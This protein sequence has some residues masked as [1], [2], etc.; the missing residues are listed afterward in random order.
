[1]KQ[2][3]IFLKKSRTRQF[4]VLGNRSGQ[5]MIEYVLMLVVTISLLFLANKVFDSM[6]KFMNKYMGDYISCLMEYGELPSWGVQDTDLKQHTSGAGGGKVCDSSFD[7]FTI[8]GG[9]PASGG[10]GG[11]GGG[12]N[13]S[14]GKNEAPGGGKNTGSKNNSNASN[15][16]SSQQS[17]SSGSSSSSSSS[18]SPYSSGQVRR[19]GSSAGGRAGGTTD[20]RV[21]AGE[22]DEKVQVIEES[23][24]ETEGPRKN[25]YAR[26]RQT[27]RIYQQDKYRAITGKLAE[28]IEKKT[29]KVE[30]KPTTTTLAKVTSGGYMFTPKKRA[31]VPPTDLKKTTFKDDGDDGSFQFGYFIKWLLIAGMILAIV[32]LIGGQI[33][34]YSKSGED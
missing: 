22:S 2:E 14:G 17:S 6:N 24:G 1:M 26:G 3:R 8:A 20:G 12:K 28:E 10:G 5:A 9:R 21:T 25:L 11:T 30:R 23:E 16:S 34:N 18:Q 13:T 31:F 4:G 15:N 33:L 19:G 7:G 27:R 29:K 32:I